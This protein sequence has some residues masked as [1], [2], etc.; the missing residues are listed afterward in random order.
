MPCSAV[1]DHVSRVLS[2]HSSSPLLFQ[3]CLLAFSRPFTNFISVWLNILSFRELAFW[4]IGSPPFLSFRQLAKGDCFFLQLQREVEINIRFISATFG[5]H[6]KFTNSL[7]TSLVRKILFPRSACIVIRCKKN[8]YVSD[9][10]F[11]STTTSLWIARTTLYRR[12]DINNILIHVHHGLW[13][14]LTWSMNYGHK[15]SSFF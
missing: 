14:Y 11:K 5:T 13:T 2:L 12:K 4:Y 3:N 1:L 10:R 15:F 6:A 8:K 9:D 7:D